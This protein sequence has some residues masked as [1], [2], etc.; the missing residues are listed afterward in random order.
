MLKYYHNFVGRSQAIISMSRSNN[1]G[2]G[3]IRVTDDSAVTIGA[4]VEVRA[5]HV[6]AVNATKTKESSDETRRG[7]RRR[8]KKLIQWWMVE[9]PDYFEVGTRV[10]STEEKADPMKFYHTCDR[11]LVYEGLRV[12]MVIAYMAATKTKTTEVGAD[13]KIYS[14][15][16]IRKINDA[17][18]FGSRTVKQV[19]S[20]TYYS[21]MH[22]FLLSFKKET[23][24]ARSHG[25][26]E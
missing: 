2:G 25:N 18:M 22:S 10:L 23:A 5:E 6:A 14:H 19:L 12:D 1:R 9:Y 11:D 4:E 26:V 17:V 21:E 7:H 16:H 3:R 20:S 24:D 8:L 13:A 15:Q